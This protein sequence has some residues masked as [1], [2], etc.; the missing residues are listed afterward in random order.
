VFLD[1]WQVCYTPLPD[2]YVA[3]Y[4]ATICP[5]LDYGNDLAGAF[6]PTNNVED[7]MAWCLNTIPGASGGVFVPSIRN[8]CYC[9]GAV[10]AGGFGNTGCGVNAGFYRGASCQKLY[11]VQAETL[12]TETRAASCVNRM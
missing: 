12:L 3:A 4:N 7:C 2:G 10:G 1:V 11:I 6:M 5:G 8:M 9:K